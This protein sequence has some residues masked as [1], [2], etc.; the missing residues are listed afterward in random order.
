MK[1]ISDEDKAGLYLTVIVHLAVLVVLLA[2]GLGYS[3]TRENSFVLD[4]SHHEELERMQKEV[5]RL[6]EEAEFKEDVSRRLQQMLSDNGVSPSGSASEIKNVAVDRGALK[7]DR[8]TDAEQLYKEA[9]ELQS[10][11]ARGYEL[12]DADRAELPSP[13]AS[14]TDKASQQQSYS[15]PSV[16]S[17]ELEGRKASKLPIPAY[18]CM[19]AG[20]VK[21][22]ISV[23]PRGD[24]ISAKIDESA[25]SE[26][27]CLRSFAVRAARLSK[28][29]IKTDAPAKQS[30]NIVYEF[31]AQ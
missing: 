24:V 4:F 18:R 10:E 13:K 9:E 31:I 16:I 17:Y 1:K 14:A 3:L 20:Q 7:D 28:F 25:S 19:G 12:P 15:G 5:A 11:L 30:G 26:D 23:N 6:K 8:G 21:V 2:S 27:R 29:Q 22:L